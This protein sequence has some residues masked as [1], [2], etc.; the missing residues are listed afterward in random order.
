MIENSFRLTAKK[1]R[2]ERSG[3]HFCSSLKARLL[4][5]VLQLTNLAFPLVVPVAKVAAECCEWDFLG[6]LSPGARFVA[7]D[8]R[9]RRTILAWTQ[10]VSVAKVAVKVFDIDFL[11]LLGVRA[12]FVAY[13]HRSQRGFKDRQGRAGRQADNFVA[14]N[15]DI[16]GHIEIV[17]RGSP[18]RNQYRDIEATGLTRI[19]NADPQRSDCC[20]R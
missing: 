14:F 2:P 5:L 20:C 18:C 7:Y 11:G 13:D 1:N 16:A 10:V 4:R 8:D 9:G 19:Q 17:T 12:R 3:R 15:G 6:H